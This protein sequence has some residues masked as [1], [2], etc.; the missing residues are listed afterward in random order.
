M[1]D[2]RDPQPRVVLYGRVGCHLCHD[3]RSALEQVA[4]Q[5]GERFAEVDIDTDP[6]LRERYS[7]LVPVVTVDG[8]EQGHWH[9]DPARVLA[10]LNR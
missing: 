8:T 9:I 10:A 2:V 4:A 6:A 5:T 3:A 7:D 1:D